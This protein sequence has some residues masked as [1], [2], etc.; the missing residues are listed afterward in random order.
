MTTRAPIE[1]RPT[2][3]LH[4]SREW[5]SSKRHQTISAFVLYA[6]V[7]IG[8]FGIHVLPD[9]ARTCVCLPGGT[10]PSFFMWDLEW[11]PHALLHGLNPFFSNAVY[12]PVGLDLGGQTAAP[13]AALLAA[14]IT[15]LFGPVVS[16][17]VLM[18]AAPML[19]AFFAFVLCRY[20]TGDF[21]SSLIGGYLFG[22]SSYML[23]QLLGH[24]HLVLIFPIPVAV[25]LTLRLIDRR[26]SERRFIAL[27]ALS[28][29]A[30]LSFSLEVAVTSV[31]L[32]GVALVVAFV[33]APAVRPQLITAI[34]PILA[35]G[36]VAAFVTSPVIYYGIKG[37]VAGNTQGL[38]DLYGGDALGFLVPTTVIRLGWRYFAAVAAG[39]TSGDLP[40]SGIYVGLPLALIV[41]RY[42]I[43]RWRRASTRILVAMLAL[44]AVLLLGSR[45]HIAGHPTIPLPWKLLEDTPL[46]EALPVRLGLYM[47]LIVAM[48]AA[49]WLAQARPR[50]WGFAKWALAAV[51]IAFLL[52]NIGVGLWRWR[53]PNPPFFTTDEYRTVLRRG[54]TALVLPYGPADFSMLWQAETGMWFR[55]TEANSKGIPAYYIPDPL[56]PALLDNAKPNPQALRSFLNGLGVEAVIVASAKPQQWPEAL[57]ALGL[58]PVS[59]GG[60]WFYQM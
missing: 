21:A 19:A 25:H 37:N 38:G 3:P 56:W 24:L 54:E 9:L 39:F 34:K 14:P 36:A 48:I 35:A 32:G 18:L 22:F 26:I 59:V 12:A 30:L 20:I 33:L 1:S 41:G 46:R 7:G 53:L 6:A 57:A 50:N 31:L 43:T 44:V 5:L 17:N 13:G 27:M 42:T 47:F 16:Y 11:W 60:V 52:P 15:L 10:D 8:F 4:I 2:G 58:R 51:S 49:M 40:E 45:L 28:L 29:A 23:G 55:I